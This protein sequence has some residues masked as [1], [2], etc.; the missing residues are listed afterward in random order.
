[1]I[2]NNDVKMYA[3]FPYKINYG[4]KDINSLIFRARMINGVYQK[5]NF[6]SYLLD[7]KQI[8]VINKVNSTFSE[9]FYIDIYKEIFDEDKTNS[10]IFTLKNLEEKELKSFILRE[11]IEGRYSWNNSV[12]C[13]NNLYDLLIYREFDNALYE[14]NGK[15]DIKHL[16]RRKN[17]NTCAGFPKISATQ[18]SLSQNFYNL[19][20]ELTFDS[21]IY[22]ELNNEK[23]YYPTNF[24]IKVLANYKN[25]KRDKLKRSEIG[26]YRTTFSINIEDDLFIRKIK[27]IR[28]IDVRNLSI[29]KYCKEF[30]NICNGIRPEILDIYHNAIQSI[31]IDSLNRYNYY[32]YTL[33]KLAADKIIRNKLISD[34]PVRSICYTNINEF[35]ED[36]PNFKNSFRKTKRKVYSFESWKV[37]LIG[38]NNPFINR[39][40]KFKKFKEQSIEKSIILDIGISEEDKKECGFDNKGYYKDEYKNKIY[41]EDP[42]SEKIVNSVYDN[43]LESII[44]KYSLDEDILNA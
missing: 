13:F 16:A 11:I 29:I 12:Q 26:C 25:I 10:E 14:E 15:K 4:D 38:E 33:K 8:E 23:V 43:F 41:L 28:V 32:L 39:N 17:G 2:E 18:N 20:L 22:D 37:S 40:K 6:S 30:R 3:V 31:D 9:N 34:Y 21:S 44:N 42:I 1:M 7:K 36:F 27:R 5:P 19:K 35:F 24:P